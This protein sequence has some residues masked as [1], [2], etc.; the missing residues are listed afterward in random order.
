MNTIDD[1]KRVYDKYNDYLDKYIKLNA[2]IN[3]TREGAK[4]SFVF[5]DLTDGTYPFVLNGIATLEM[6]GKHDNKYNEEH[7]VDYN[8]LE[9]LLTRGTSVEVM[10]KIVKSP[11]GCTQAFELQVFSLKVIGKVYD[12]IIYPITKSNQTNFISLRQHEGMRMRTQLL[13]TVYRM[14]SGLIDGMREFMKNENV[15][16][17]DPNIMTSS[18][19]EGAGEVF[20]VG[21]DIFGKN[22]KGEDK[23]LF[24]TVSSQL[25]L[26]AIAVGMRKAYTMNKS[27]R[28]EKSNSFKHV[29]EFMHVEAELSFIT[30][31]DLID[32][33][34]RFVKYSINYMLQ[35]YNSEYEYL[36]SKFSPEE[37]RGRKAELE[38]FVSVPF[39]KLKYCD[40]IKMI[41]DD[42]KDKKV[43]MKVRP[44]FGD[45]LGSEHENY[46]VKKFD[47]FVFVTHWPHKIKSFYMKQCTD[48]SGE[49][50]SFD[51][52]APYV[53]EMF[54]GSMREENYEKLEAEMKAR[55]MNVNVLQ[56]YLD[57]RKMGTVPHG[58]WGCGFDRMLMLVTGLVSIKD[59]IPFPVCYEH[60]DY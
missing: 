17:V 48:G 49:C 25:Q 60:C 57:L 45:D 13:S 1:I 16:Q 54:G 22:D 59:V 42:L 37:V 35:N 46:L 33:T 26:E 43:K 50:E 56:W 58:G 55:N 7:H 12:P 18:D 23:K 39:I 28:A 29:A 11:E 14:R 53:G 27:F 41:Q 15:P 31:T 40:A 34:E 20:E 51:L 21:P 52:L 3:N 30:L 4:G 38:K 8:K 19:C 24:L 5:I 2:W 6:Y 47:G 36:N 32:F 44:N 10:G 9:E